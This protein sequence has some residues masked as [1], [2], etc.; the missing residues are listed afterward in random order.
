MCT[1]TFTKRDKGKTYDLPCGKCVECINKRRNG[2]AF[3]LEQ[4]ANISETAL[5]VTLT[6]DEDNIPL[7]GLGYATL[8]K[9]D[10]QLFF[11]RLRKLH[12]QH[13]E[14]K[15]KYYAAGE[16]SD[17]WRPHYHL[18][19]FNAWITDIDKAWNMGHTHFGK[20]EPASVQYTL[21]YINKV[22]INKLSRLAEIK[23]VGIE[24]EFQLIS[25]GLGAV[26]L[27]S[28]QVKWHLA[29]VENRCY[30]PIEDGKK[31]SMPRYYKDKIYNELQKK[32]IL[33]AFQKRV[34][35]TKIE[36]V[37]KSWREKEEKTRRFE[38]SNKIK[39]EKFQ[40]QTTENSWKDLHPGITDSTKS[41]S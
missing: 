15:I 39:H 38:R 11:K 5:F 12:E 21:K 9:K 19:I 41:K 40:T 25:K 18:I 2:W 27:K 26:Y 33:K 28:N 31:L 37:E 1:N 14:S 23:S 10:L 35:E 34:E 30:I 3:R 16:Y 4:E 29:D 13:S 20:V 17:E 6:Y 24:P 36:D 22:S 7:V 8:M 32:K